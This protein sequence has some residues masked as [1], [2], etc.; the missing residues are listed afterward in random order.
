VSGAIGGPGPLDINDLTAQLALLTTMTDGEWRDF[1]ACTPEQQML[2]AQ[3]YRDMDWAKSPPT[4]ARVLEILAVIGTIA[5]V[6]SGVAGAAT[7][8]AALKAVL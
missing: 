8:L 3:G 4:L 6:V 2:I 1:F 7:A 5:G